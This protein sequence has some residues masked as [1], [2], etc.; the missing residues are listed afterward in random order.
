MGRRKS[1]LADPPIKLDL[2][3]YVDFELEAEKFELTAGR[4][5]E[6]A[7]EVEETSPPTLTV[8]STIR[9][10][11]LRERLQAIYNTHLEQFETCNWPE[12]GYRYRDV[13][14]FRAHERMHLVRDCPDFRVRAAVLRDIENETVSTIERSLG[15]EGA[16]PAGERVRIIEVLRSRGMLPAGLDGGNSH[17]HRQ[18]EQDKDDR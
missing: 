10:S 4:V 14:D 8:S 16:L 13:H 5:A 17:P 9:E 11:E 3:R 7:T 15:A 1:K 6:I 2:K 18:D 12:C